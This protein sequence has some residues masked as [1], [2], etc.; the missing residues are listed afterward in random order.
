[1]TNRHFLSY[2]RA[3]FVHPAL[4]I[5]TIWYLFLTTID[6]MRLCGKK[7][8]FLYQYT[9]FTCQCTQ[10]HV[11]N[12]DCHVKNVGVSQ[13]HRDTASAL[14]NYAF[15]LLLHICDIC[16]TTD[17]VE[18][19]NSRSPCNSYMQF[20][21]FQNED[22]TESSIHPFKILYLVNVRPYRTS[23]C[24]LVQADSMHGVCNHCATYYARRFFTGH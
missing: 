21:S 15:W 19:I 3:I 4:L 1:M 12:S 2:T 6:R 8:C 20:L 24:Q 9:C 10:N 7:V 14:V 11:T 16:S 5:W 22:I 23:G 18:L 13:Y 17:W